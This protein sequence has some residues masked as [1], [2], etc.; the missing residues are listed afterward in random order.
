M[1]YKNSYDLARVNNKRF[2]S[3]GG[4]CKISTSVEKALLQ[5]QYFCDTLIEIIFHKSQPHTLISEDNTR[6][7]CIVILMIIAH[8]STIIHYNSI[9]LIRFEK[10]FGL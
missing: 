3:L 7:V 4:S 8:A 9:L 1:K 6:Q 2:L 5:N 10:S